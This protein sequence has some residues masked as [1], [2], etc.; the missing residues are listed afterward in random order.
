MIWLQYGKQPVRI[1]GEQSA[2]L[3]EDLRSCMP[4]LI[5]LGRI[6][7]GCLMTPGPC[8]GKVNKDSISEWYRKVL[9][10]KKKNGMVIR[11]LFRNNETEELSYWAQRFRNWHQLHCSCYNINISVKIWHINFQ[12]WHY[13]H[14]LCFGVSGLDLSSYFVTKILRT[15]LRHLTLRRLMSYLYGAPI[16][17]VSRSHTT[18][19]HSR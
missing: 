12:T 14:N 16:L 19:Q 4:V 6:M 1:C 13:S 8:L 15:L 2:M 5:C 18:T 9:R 17:D 3:T 11:R 10:T 7:I